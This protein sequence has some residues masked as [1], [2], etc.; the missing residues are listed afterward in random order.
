[1]KKEAYEFEQKNKG[2]TVSQTFT[3]IYVG[4]YIDPK[5]VAHEHIIQDKKIALNQPKSKGGYEE[6]YELTN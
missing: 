5:Q 1:M 2:S 3:I 4:N 6:F